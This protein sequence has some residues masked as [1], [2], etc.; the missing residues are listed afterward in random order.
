L[1]HSDTAIKFGIASLAEA[2]AYLK[3]SILGPRL[4]TCAELVTRVA[5][6]SI[7]EIFGYPDYL[8]FRSSMTLFAKATAENKVFND[9]L[10]KFFAGEYDALTLKLLEQ[11]HVS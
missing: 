9:A 5:G 11:N 10:E 2:A 3:H 1:G 8:K 4:R 7:E 6:R